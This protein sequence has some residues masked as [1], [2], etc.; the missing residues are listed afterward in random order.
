MT[1]GASAVGV[2]LAAHVVILT[3]MTSQGPRA[4]VSDL[5]FP[6][7]GAAAAAFLF[8]TA[9]RLR[10]EP[11]QLAG[12]LL[13]GA[14]WLCT[15]AR[16]FGWWVAEVLLR[17]PPFPSVVD[18]VNLAGY[19]LFLAG[20]IFLSPMRGLLRARVGLLVDIAIV[21]TATALILWIFAFIP[22][23]QNGV[24][25]PSSPGAF[26]LIYPAG[27]FLEIAAA[28]ILVYRPRGGAFA[29]PARLLAAAAVTRVL[30]DFAFGYLNLKAAYTSGALFE[31]GWAVSAALCILAG[32]RWTDPKAR[33]RAGSRA[34]GLDETVR[35]LGPMW[36]SHLPYVWIAGTLF[37]LAW[38]RFHPL[39]VNWIVF[40]GMTGAI[41]LLAATR[42]TLTLVQNW[43]M[44]GEL[45]GARNALELRVKE[46]TAEL[47]RANRELLLL[48]R[49][50]TAMTAEPELTP[51][52]RRIVETVADA[53]DYSHVSLSLLEKDTLVLQHRRGF[54]GAPAR[55][56]IDQGVSGRVA[57][58]GRAE[59][60][61]PDKDCDSLRMS[62]GAR[63]EVVVPILDGRTVL[64]TISVESSRERPLGPED[65]RVV[66]AVGEQAGMAIARAMVLSYAQ[67]SEEALQRERESLETRVRERTSELERANEELIVEASE[68]VRQEEQLSLL[69]RAVERATESVMI[70]DCT[71]VLLYANPAFELIT[72]RSRGAVMA[73]QFEEFFRENP[74]RPR[75][76]QEAVRGLKPWSGVLTLNRT[77]GR[78]LIVDLSINPIL[79]DAGRC[80][81]WVGVM[82]DITERALLEERVRQG[83]KLEALGRFA[84]GIA[85][86]FNNLLA[87]IIG[88]VR[89]VLENHDI[90]GEARRGM[91]LVA[92][93]A[94]RAVALTRRLLAFSRREARDVR[95]LDLNAV[96]RGMAEMVSRLI[97]AHVRLDVR[98]E[99]ELA[100]IFADRVQ[101]EQ[102]VLNLAA[103]SADAMPSGGA[104]EIETANATV[105]DILPGHPD[106]VPKGRYVRLQVRDTGTGIPAEI[107]EHI[108]EPFF[109]TKE[110]GKG[111]GLGLA[112]VYGVVRQ[113]EGHICVDS[114]PG[115]GTVVSIYLPAQQGAAE[116]PAAAPVPAETPHGTE[117]VLVVDDDD[118]VRSLTVLMLTRLGYATLQASDG[119]RALW[120]LSD[121][122]HVDL[123]LTDVSMP[124]MTGVTLA[125]TIGRGA[126]PP[127]LLYMSGYAADT[128][129]DAGR[130]FLQKPF[131]EAALA[132][133][134]RGA[135]DRT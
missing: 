65:L 103:N 7:E 127:R 97:G 80:A 118:H 104:L 76:M 112:T 91:V 96:I 49:V 126:S 135:L 16:D 82:N 99:A 92:D 67:E 6:A 74:K 89:I 79:D 87:V 115:A 10:A 66:S 42:Q 2:V 8:L 46:R 106:T 134:V 114:A 13:L 17:E 116:S 41:I 44:S 48:D 100:P 124:G 56:P 133:A 60:V 71:G 88:Y 47:E 20:I 109:T 12:W 77:D 45:L 130:E 128:L 39:P 121:G 131:S 25:N 78:G 113:S 84:G 15:S 94:E 31:I 54:A 129:S 22:L 32:L 53:F 73:G 9:V 57:R 59:L 95:L 23:R 117:T 108:F 35:R 40:A 75:Q 52:L 64:G 4:L 28:V 55:I 119:E 122:G 101:V 58:T 18:L 30:T 110:P 120:I 123:V 86:D 69:S 81:H 68:R 61:S 111:T 21:L 51:M 132:N 107:R 34:A 43:R 1:W 33:A 63:S 3:V 19:P 26:A 70:F 98:G 37:L 72:G 29:W 93:T 125:D 105:A 27:D 5:L 83:E 14:S 38:T 50:R 36:L 62:A 102:I 11:R 24:G 90:A 85:H